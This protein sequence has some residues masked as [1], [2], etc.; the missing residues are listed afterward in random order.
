MQLNTSV[1]QW[2]YNTARLI[3]FSHSAAQLWIINCITAHDFQCFYIITNQREQQPG[4]LFLP[5]QTPISFSAVFQANL[6][7]PT[8]KLGSFLPQ[9]GYQH[10]E[11]AHPIQ[12]FEVIVANHRGFVVQMLPGITDTQPILSHM[13][14]LLQQHKCRGWRAAAKAGIPLRDHWAALLKST[15]GVGRDKMQQQPFC[16]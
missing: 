11:K 2:M 10:P 12:L 14:S 4:R 8:P 15:L 16:V 1:S 9:R 5:S 7:L 3:H 13:H 6:T